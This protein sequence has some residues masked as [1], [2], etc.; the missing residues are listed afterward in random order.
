M[1]PRDTTRSCT[2]GHP[3]PR[4]APDRHPAPGR[5]NRVA[6]I[7][8]LIDHAL[9]EYEQDTARSSSTVRGR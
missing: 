3:R 2:P 4:P 6:V 8:D 9:A 7:L 5:F 1:H